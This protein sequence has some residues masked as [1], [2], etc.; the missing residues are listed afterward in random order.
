VGGIRCA[1][2]IIDQ[3]NHLTAAGQCMVASLHLGST[4]Q[5]EPTYDQLYEFQ[6]LAEPLARCMARIEASVRGEE[7]YNPPAKGTPDGKA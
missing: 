7:P 5:R 2:E 1:K 6:K 3:F 4:E